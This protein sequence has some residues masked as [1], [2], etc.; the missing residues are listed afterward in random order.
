[1]DFRNGEVLMTAGLDEWPLAQD[2]C[3]LDWFIREERLEAR[4]GVSHF[5]LPP[6]YREYGQGVEHPQ[7]HIPFV[8]FP[9]W[10]YCPR[11][12]AMERLRLNEGR[13]AM[14]LSELWNSPQK[15]AALPCTKSLCRRVR[16]G[17]Y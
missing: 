4:L 9:R 11:S 2:K 17:T 1:M 10:H 14:R 12:G 16:D 3:P 5:R 7:K 8:R 13:K 15:K 6:E